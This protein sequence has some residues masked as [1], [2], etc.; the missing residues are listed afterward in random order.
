MVD[1]RRVFSGG[2]ARRR[3]LLLALAM[4]AG[5]VPVLFGPNPAHAAVPADSDWLGWLNLY[6]SMAGVGP[7]TEDGTLSAGDRLHA[8]YLI[9][10][11]VLTHD[12]DP[13]SPWYT[14]DGA[15]AGHQSNIAYVG[16]GA[17][18]GRQFLDVWMRAPFHEVGLLDPKLQRVGFGTFSNGAVTAGALNVEAGRGAV[19]PGTTF[20]VVFPASGSTMA[21][22]LYPGGEYPDPLTPCG[23]SAPVGQP[24]VIQFA[25]PGAVT[26]VSFGPAGGAGLPLCWYDGTNYTNPDPTAQAFGRGVLAA[27][28]AVIVFPK[29]PLQN[30]QTYSFSVTAGGVTGSS[31]FVVGP[32]SSA[33]VSPIGSAEIINPT[34]PGTVRVA[35]WTFDQDNPTVPLDVQ[36][37]VDGGVVSTVKASVSRPDVGTAYPAAGANH[38][39]DSTIDVAGGSHNVCLVALNTRAGSDKPLGC[40]TVSV[41]SASPFGALDAATA[42]NTRLV[43]VRGWTIDAN[44]SAPITVHLYVDGVKVTETTADID[45]PDVAAAF[46]GWG[47]KHGFE[48]DLPA[49]AGLH[50]VCAWGINVGKGVNSM[51]GC[52]Q[53]DNGGGSGFHPMAPTRVLD[54]RTTTGGWNG[55][56]TAGAPRALALAGST[57]PGAVPSTAKAVVLNVTV[58]GGTANSFLTAFPA[59]TAVPNAS[60]LNFGAGQTTANLVTVRVGAFG[61]V[62]F[63]NAAG[64]VHVIADIVGWYDDG[65]GQGDL[66]TGITP[67]RLLDS[68]TSTGGFNGRLGA[69]EGNVRSLPVKGGSVPATA[70]AVVMNLT[71]TGGSANSFL[72]VFPTGTTRP[73]SSNLNFATGQTIPN[74]VTVPIG[75]D[76]KVNFFN[77]AGTVDV[78]A[79]VVGY[80]DP[81]AGGSRFHALDPTRILDDRFS[82]GLSGKFT[83]DWARKLQVTGTGGVPAGATGI[84]MNTTATNGTANSFLTVFPDDLFVTRPNASNVNFGAGQTVPNLVMG[85]IGA[86]GAIYIYNQQGFVDVIGDAVGYF[87]A[88]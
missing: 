22:R 71:A 46:P 13:S 67:V 26:A 47:S 35:G 73:N 54:S 2:S 68:R 74:L 61:Q 84:V 80:F 50:Q 58:T 85:K 25:N 29:A 40:K 34:A 28:N 66:F 82:V 49:P 48:L 10:E 9:E 57:A 5:L 3:A 81:T 51:L 62:N 21:L 18:T 88:T 86:T 38:G 65:S 32:E 33:P 55:P 4:V 14:P 6:R 27:R 16:G 37:Q 39:F 41:V 60:N 45:R 79:D 24:L 17:A 56:V 15:A 64:S 31:T 42:V 23:F 70:T 72:Q 77:A 78:V 76:G 19:P 75:T 59:G 30:G 43:H 87:A 20:P 36:V 69:G 8:R 1:G 44:T 63:A 53:V 11:G 7:V 52:Q 83:P 12:E